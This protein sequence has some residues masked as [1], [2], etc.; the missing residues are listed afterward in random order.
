MKLFTHYIIPFFFVRK[1]APAAD[2]SRSKKEDVIET[3]YLID[4][5]NYP[6]LE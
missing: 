6:V 1:E 2:K 4:M 3:D 5:M